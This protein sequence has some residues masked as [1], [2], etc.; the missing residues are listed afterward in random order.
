[1]TFMDVLRK[2]E[3]KETVEKP[4]SSI[5]AD[6]WDLFDRYSKKS[7]AISRQALED[8]D[9]AL[10][11]F[12]DSSPAGEHPEEGMRYDTFG[13]ILDVTNLFRESFRTGKVNLNAID[14]SEEAREKFVK[15]ME[16]FSRRAEDLEADLFDQASQE[17]DE[18]AD[19][20]WRQNKT[21]K[22]MMAKLFGKELVLQSRVRRTGS[23]EEEYTTV[24]SKNVGG[25]SS[26]I[27][28]KLVATLREPASPIQESSKTLQT[29]MT[30]VAKNGTNDSRSKQLMKKLHKNNFFDRKTTSKIQEFLY[31][32]KSLPKHVRKLLIEREAEWEG[33][34][35]SSYRMYGGKPSKELI[36][37]IFTSQGIGRTNV[38]GGKGL[39]SKLTR[40]ASMNVDSMMERVEGI[41]YD[42]KGE[43]FHYL[44]DKD[45][46]DDIIFAIY[47]VTAKL[48]SLLSRA[49]KGRADVG[50]KSKKVR[51]TAEEDDGYERLPPRDTWGTPKAETYLPSDDKRL[52]VN[53]PDEAYIKPVYNEINRLLRFLHFLLAVNKITGQ[54]HR[55]KEQRL[56]I[57]D[58]IQKFGTRS[59]GQYK[60]EFEKLDINAIDVTEST[61]PFRSMIAAY[62][63]YKPKKKDR[64][65]SV[66]GAGKEFQFEEGTSREDIADKLQ[67]ELAQDLKQ[68][69]SRLN[70]SKKEKTIA[71]R[72]QE[73]QAINSLIAQWKPKTKTLERTKYE[74]P[75]GQQRI[76]QLLSEDKQMRDK[77]TREI[78][79]ALKFLKE[80][81][82]NNEE[83]LERIKDKKGLVDIETEK[84][85]R[86]LKHTL[87]LTEQS[88]KDFKLPFK[89]E[90]SE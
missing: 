64:K 42:G 73:I 19:K 58:K 43:D 56:E 45:Y 52:Q 63:K 81:I 86:A 49:K 46:S 11:T 33:D 75:E 24:T 18:V 35:W 50:R 60:L 62:D 74:E 27:L 48:E 59:R 14:A 29:L 65:I 25:K 68:L 13:E 40:Y 2:E 39:R 69:Q 80:S 38:E 23:G 78:G 10:Q 37:D 88:V 55:L 61:S 26:G 70:R 21:F 16:K 53:V 90:E 77:F 22:D 28:E 85:I 9:E 12:L 1:M 66:A 76:A 6:V 34:D 89:L 15:D 3:E 41:M 47:R 57:V 5:H 87:K 71:A 17:D 54:S 79:S 51:E 67:D 7:K 44:F 84:K 72:E 30:N 4:T 32:G 36:I 20:Y 83:K 8:A 82:A 31:N